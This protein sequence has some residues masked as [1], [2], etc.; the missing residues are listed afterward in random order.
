MKREYK[1]ARLSM[2]VF[3]TGGELDCLVDCSRVTYRK[4]VYLEP[5]GREQN[6]SSSDTAL[7]LLK[8]QMYFI[9]PTLW[10]WKD[11]DGGGRVGSLCPTP[12]AQG[13]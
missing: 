1:H 10:V 9:A 12:W 3:L 13:P 6:L 2:K 5:E 8:S 4:P 11:V 7:P